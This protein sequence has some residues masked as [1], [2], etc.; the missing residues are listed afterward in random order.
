MR[1]KNMLRSFFL[2]SI[3]TAT[4]LVGLPTI[5][6]ASECGRSYTPQYVRMNEGGVYRNNWKVGNFIQLNGWNDV[7]RYGV[8]VQYAQG[9][10]CGCT[11]YGGNPPRHSNGN[12]TCN[13]AL[14]A[15][16]R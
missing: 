8:S 12:A 7:A 15:G 6:S 14:D 16:L 5:A 4:F 1:H 2:A 10:T 9:H 11:Q 13:R 3:S